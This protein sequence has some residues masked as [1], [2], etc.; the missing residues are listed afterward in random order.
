MA[1][2]KVSRFSLLHPMQELK[3]RLKGSQGDIIVCIHLNHPLIVTVQNPPDQPNLLLSSVLLCHAGRAETTSSPPVQ[4]ERDLG[5][6]FLP[7]AGRPW[8]SSGV[9]EQS[10]P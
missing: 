6:A 4:P 3:L 5:K 9:K 1:G 2:R 10:G 7:T 8:G